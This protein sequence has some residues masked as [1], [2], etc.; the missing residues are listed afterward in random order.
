M[1][2]I[3]SIALRGHILLSDLWILIRNLFSISK[4]F[5]S[6]LLWDSTDTWNNLMDMV[7]VSYI[8]NLELRYP[9]YKNSL[10]CSN[11]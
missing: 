5:P 11:L 7:Y 8:Q 9:N 6:S 2:S 1:M 4:K 3:E 10:S